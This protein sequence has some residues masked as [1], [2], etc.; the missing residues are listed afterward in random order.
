MMNELKTRKEKIAQNLVDL[1]KLPENI[2]V[3]KGQTIQMIKITEQEKL[4]VE[5]ETAK[6]K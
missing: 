4:K 5:E 3:E 2:A 1:E 6:L